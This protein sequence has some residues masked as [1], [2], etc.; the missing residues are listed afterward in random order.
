MTSKQRRSLRRQQQHNATGPTTPAG[1]AISAQNSLKHGLTAQSPVL[2][3]ENQAEFDQ[4]LVKYTE[5]FDPQTGHLEFLVHL[6][7][8]AA[9]R[10]R[11]ID[12]IEAAALELLFDPANASL[13]IYHKIAAAMGDPALVPEKLLRHRNAAERSYHKALNELRP[14]KIRKQNELPQ[15]DKV[16]NMSTAEGIQANIERQKLYREI[17]KPKPYIP[18]QAPPPIRT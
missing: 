8:A 13:S 10:I 11:R 16:S 15:P 3:T 12:A 1:K 6:L 2:P 17:G 14:P 7:A 4:T 9:W 5:E 18:D